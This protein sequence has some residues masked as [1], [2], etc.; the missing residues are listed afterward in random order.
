[1][2]WCVV[3]APVG[4]HAQDLRPVQVLEVKYLKDLL[5]LMGQGLSSGWTPAASQGLG[6]A[7][8]TLPAC[9]EGSM[10]TPG[11]PDWLMCGACGGAKALLCY[12]SL[13]SGGI[14][15][16]VWSPRLGSRE[17]SG[18]HYSLCCDGLFAA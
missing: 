17:A 14:V 13:A 3:A 8:M 4:L 18:K 16:S 10:N 11:P 12:H 15:T 1:M 9:C 2:G 7:A 5:P 6:V